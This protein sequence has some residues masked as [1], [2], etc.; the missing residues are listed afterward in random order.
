MMG[1]GTADQLRFKNEE[2]LER[3]SR[4]EL[5]L[6]IAHDQIESLHQ[7]LAIPGCPKRWECKTFKRHYN[8]G[9]NLD[10]KQ[11]FKDYYEQRRL[12]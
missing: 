9:R 11:Y 7:K 10:R 5:E 6:E 1:V 3:L 8:R 4:A 12:G 2:L